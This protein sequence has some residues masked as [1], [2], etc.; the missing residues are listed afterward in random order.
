M[1]LGIIALVT[2]CFG[3]TG[4]ICGA[5]AIIFG[6]LALLSHKAGKGMAITG[7]VCGIVALIPAIYFVSAATSIMSMF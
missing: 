5:L 7:L 6:G 2:S 4:I 1:V 3:V